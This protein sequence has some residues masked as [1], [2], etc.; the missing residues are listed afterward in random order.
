MNIKLVTLSNL[1]KFKELLL[2]IITTKLSTGLAT[3]SDTGH[4]HDNATTSKDGF[5]SAADK[6]K[7]DGIQNEATNTAAPVNADWNATSGLAQI[8]N[9]PT[10][11]V[12]DS[13][14]SQTST[15]G[16]QNKIATLNMNGV[17]CSTAAGNQIK[18]VDMPGFVLYAG[19]TI[20]VLF[21]NACTVSRPQLKVGN[22]A[23]KKIIAY[24]G[25]IPVDSN[26][27]K[28]SS[29]KWRG[30]STAFY[31]VW[32]P[33]TTLELMYDGTNWVVMGDP[34]IENYFGTYSG[35]EKK[36]N[37]LIKQWGLANKTSNSSGGSLVTVTGL[38]FTQPPMV[39]FSP[40][41]NNGDGS[42]WYPDI[43]SI[44]DSSFT[45]NARRGV[46]DVPITWIAIGY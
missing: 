3:K 29:G 33:Y 23:A 13:E 46:D 5:M 34:V 44:T 36:A 18:S 25:G 38:L 1:I 15:N 2:E 9:K 32:Q 6:T 35:Y 7:L 43:E 10:I 28:A 27:L 30:A 21:Q 4:R 16:I 41:F 14:L 17:L 40:L 12:I 19:A 37:G 31:E 45:V 24:R 22:T 20:R 39:V 42:I 8:L 26:G 11:L